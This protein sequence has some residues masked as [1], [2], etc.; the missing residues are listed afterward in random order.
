MVEID[1]H[2]LFS[3]YFSESGKLVSKM[4]E[5]IEA[6]LDEDE[7]TLVVVFIDE[8]ESMT[9]T[10]EQSVHSNEPR[11]ALRVQSYLIKGQYPVS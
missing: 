10:R 2:S 11:D 5:S 9:S 1:A 3:K 4:F 8:I 6:M 7:S